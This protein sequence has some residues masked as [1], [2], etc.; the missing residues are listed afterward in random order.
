MTARILHVSD[1]HIGRREEPEPIAALRELAAELAPELVLAT[2]DLAHRGKRTQLERA[3]ALL[4]A[5]GPPILAVPGNHDIPYTFPARFTHPFADWDRV[6]GST[7]PVHAAENILVV[8][9]NSVRAW[10]QQGGAVTDAALDRVAERLSEAPTGA[11]RVAALHHHLAA[12]PWRAARKRPL[13]RRGHVLQS[14]AAAGAELVVGGHVHQAAIAE[15]RE[16]QAVESG[17][18]GSLVLATAPGLGRPRPHRQREAHGVNVYESDP[19]TLR[20]ITFSWDG[21]S[22]AEVGRRS[23]PRG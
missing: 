22:F 10:R 3:A 1:L 6:F 18:P 4:H 11:L 9:L 20:V 19:G 5:L 15:L 17:R 2:G 16:F 14:L 23:F 7:E 12:P 8:G 21:A 13:K